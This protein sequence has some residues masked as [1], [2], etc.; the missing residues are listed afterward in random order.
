MRYLVTIPCMDMVH[1]FFMT[2]LLAMRKPEGAE[3]AICSSSLVYD[4]RNTLAQKAVN[5][6]FDRVLWLDSDMIFEP[7]IMERLIEDMNAGARFVTALYFTRKA[8][9]VP[10]IYRALETMENGGTH[11][12]SFEDYPKNALFEIAGCGMG[13]CMM[14]TDVLRAAGNYGKP[15]SPMDGWG[16]DFSFDIRVRQAGIGIF[17]DS[18]IIAG[19]IGQSIINESTWEGRKRGKRR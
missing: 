3:V 18:R 16:E 15:F 2:S 6:G 8:P 11:G 4:S 7:D 12:V 5:E 13:A 9:V 1:T 17:C 14:D 19:H 10:C